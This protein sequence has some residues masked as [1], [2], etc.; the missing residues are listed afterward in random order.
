MEDIKKSITVAKFFLFGHKC[1]DS[2]YSK[3][4][5]GTTENIKEYFKLMNWEQTKKSFNCLFKWRSYFKP[6]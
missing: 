4:W 3:V 1:V 5:A 6:N 2:N